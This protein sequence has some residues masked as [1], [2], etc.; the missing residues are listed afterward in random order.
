MKQKVCFSVKS[1]I[2]KVWSNAK[3]GTTA[4]LGLAKGGPQEI[5]PKFKMIQKTPQT[6]PNFNS[7]KQLLSIGKNMF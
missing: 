7:S 1:K 4:T 5:F 6:T 3:E 2:G